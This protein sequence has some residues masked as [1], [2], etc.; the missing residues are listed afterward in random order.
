MGID[1]S[2]DPT[3]PNLLRWDFSGAWTLDDFWDVVAESHDM[4][5]EIDGTFDMVLNGNNTPTPALPL[6]AFQRAF[7]QASPKQN[8]VVIVNE[9]PLVR[10]LMQVLQRLRVPKTDK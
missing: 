5:E 7:R 2:W 4:V 3:A 10:S 1:V 9:S 8:L 6:A